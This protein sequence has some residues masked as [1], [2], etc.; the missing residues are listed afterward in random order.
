MLTVESDGRLEAVI[1]RNIRANRLESLIEP[2]VAMVGDGRPGTVSIDQLASEHFMPGFVKMD[3][4]GA[5]ASAL[6]GAPC[7]LSRCDR[8]LIETHGLDVENECLALLA[9]HGFRVELQ[10]T[11]R[12]LA[13]HRPT[14]H[15][16]WVIAVRSTAGQRRAVS[17]PP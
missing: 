12:W 10:N 5:E 4:E 1:R 13:D 3:I 7:T 2:R 6:R 15:N 14:E 11:R 8:W 17:A 9:D 16:R